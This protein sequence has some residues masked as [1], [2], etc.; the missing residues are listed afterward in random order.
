M[1]SQHLDHIAPIS[2]R[3]L[4]RIC[5]HLTDRNTRRVNEC[6]EF[7]PACPAATGGSPVL[8]CDGYGGVF[9]HGRLAPGQKQTSRDTRAWGAKVIEQMVNMGVEPRT[10]ALLAPR[11]KPTELIDRYLHVRQ[12]PSDNYIAS[13]VWATQLIKGRGNAGR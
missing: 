3:D 8:L 4:Q 6:S 11:S 5:S 12:G 13:T 10:L 9:H 2:T 1:Q 7:F